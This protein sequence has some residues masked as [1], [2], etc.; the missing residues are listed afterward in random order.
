MRVWPVTTLPQSNLPSHKLNSTWTVNAQAQHSVVLKLK[1][2]KEMLGRL[3]SV[4]KQSQSD[5]SHGSRGGAIILRVGVVALHA[6]LSLALYVQFRKCRVYSVLCRAV[7]LLIALSVGS[8]GSSRYHL[9]HKHETIHNDTPARRS[10]D[11][12]HRTL[13]LLEIHCEP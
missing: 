12:R 11:V 10:H 4:P 5:G 1:P 2:C 6:L 9:L 8:S 7:L 13:D 3:Q